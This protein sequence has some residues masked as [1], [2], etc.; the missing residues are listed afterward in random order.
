MKQEVISNEVIRITVNEI[1]KYRIKKNKAKYSM[2]DRM[3]VILHI[4]IIKRE[5]WYD[6]KT[7]GVNNRRLINRQSRIS[8]NEQRILGVRSDHKTVI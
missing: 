5:V 8:I 6:V 3:N 1:E 2:E 4:F 7:T